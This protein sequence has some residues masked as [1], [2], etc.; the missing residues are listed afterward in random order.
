MFAAAVSTRQPHPQ[1]AMKA[2]AVA[3]GTVMAGAAFLGAAPAGPTA[4]AGLVDHVQRDVALAAAPTF[5]DSL[6]ALLD[7][8][9]IGQQQLN[10]LIVV[11]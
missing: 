10:E 3:A 7:A 9:G 1:L 2:G 8:L 4:S 11:K 5:N 6:K